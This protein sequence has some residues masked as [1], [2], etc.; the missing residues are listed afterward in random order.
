MNTDDNGVQ[1][2]L[3]SYVLRPD[4]FH[5]DA[6]PKH[7]NR[8]V[9]AH[10]VVEKVGRETR[11]KSLLRVEKLVNFYDLQEVCG[12][13]Q[14]LLPLSP[15]AADVGKAAVIARTIAATCRPAEAQ[16]MTA[17]SGA[18]IANAQNS[19]DIVELLEL[20]DR[21]GPGADSRAL[22]GRIVQLR[23]AAS[24]RA[25]ADYQARLETS[26][27]DEMRGLRLDRV[28]R[29]N[30][31]K[32]QVLAMGDRQKR[33]GEEIKMYLTLE[34]GY[35][36]YLTPWAAARLRRET[37]GQGPAEQGVRDEGASKRAELAK[38]FQ[39]VGANLN[40]LPDVDPENLPSLRV[41]CLRAVEYFGGPLSA[42]ERTFIAKNAGHQ[43]DVLSNE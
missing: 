1:Q 24:A 14:S 5:G 23:T 6:I 38:M 10:F 25:H 35:L 36:E 2:Q 16:K 8:G 15:V 31:T 39:I 42:E 17:Y 26:R 18:L 40:R 29:A 7:L 34:Y 20:Q 27:L 32:A 21:L 33:I 13:L 37:W 3:E 9:V 22:E 43:V 41:R 12:H 4:A 19:A 30:D 11:Y 28:R